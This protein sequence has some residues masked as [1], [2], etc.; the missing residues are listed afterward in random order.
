MVVALAVPI[1]MVVASWA[2]FA[3]AQLGERIRR[4]LMLLAIILLM[5][6]I[7]ALWVT[8]YHAVYAGSG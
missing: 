1:T 2:G 5:V 6:P 3:M 4:R 7:T 8:R